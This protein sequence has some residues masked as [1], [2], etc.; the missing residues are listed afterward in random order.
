MKNKLLTAY[1]LM[2]LHATWGWAQEP[3]TPK[4]NFNGYGTFGLVHSSEDQADFVADIFDPDGAGHSS[5]VSPEVDSR[6]GLQLSADFTPELSA[7]GQIVFEQRYDGTYKPEIEWANIR[8]QITPRLSAR[9]GRVVLPTFLSSEYRNVGYALPWIRPP[10]EVYRLVPVSSTDAVSLAYRFRT[11]AFNH[12]LQALY[13]GRDLDFPGPDNS[14]VKARDAMTLAYTL[15]RGAATF[16]SAYSE[17]RLTVE[18]LEPLFDGFR[19]FGPPGEAIAARF[20]VDD[21]RFELISVG[22][23]YDPGEW[24]VMGELARARNQSVLSDSHGM[25]ISGGYRFGSVTP[26]LT[27]ARVEVDS[28]TSS[29]GVP[30]EGLPPPR[31]GLARVLNAALNDQLGSAP[32]QKSLSLGARW[33]FAPDFSLKLQFDHMDLDDGSAGLLIDRQPGFQPGGTV[34][35]YSASIDFVF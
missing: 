17:G 1:S 15:E 8:Y 28:D 25:Y 35:L 14:K 19:Q 34:R 2:L 13:G 22:A 32:A 21:K 7:V 4:W 27:L 33:D 12:A 16:F 5:D 26:Y 24:F 30:L 31:A 18:T 29:P 3:H 6:L 9:A 11:G 20:G 23:Q 10:L